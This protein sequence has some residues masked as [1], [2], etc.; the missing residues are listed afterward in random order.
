M[1]FSER[2]RLNEIQLAEASGKSLWTDEIPKSLRVKTIRLARSFEDELNEWP[3]R[4]NR[5]FVLSEA[6]ELLLNDTGEIHL[7]N[8]YSDDVEDMG[9]FILNCDKS[10]FPDAIEALS[11][12]ISTND[13]IARQTSLADQFEMGMNELLKSYRV[14]FTLENGEVIPLEDTAVHSEIVLPTLR[15]LNKRG[16]GKVE[17]PFREAIREIA[18]NKPDDAVTDATTAL[19]EGLRKIGCTGK[20]LKSL[21]TSAKSTVLKGADAKFVDAVDSLIKW[22]SAARVNDGDNHKT[23]ETDDERAWF[24]VNTVGILLLYLSKNK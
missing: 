3:R 8:S 18:N 11:A 15:L 6:R 2:K 24:V 7:H 16:W 21:L 20:D 19:Q 9:N 12:A 13:Q 4:Y 14:N 22:A 1:F 17:E 10:R 5:L 23:A